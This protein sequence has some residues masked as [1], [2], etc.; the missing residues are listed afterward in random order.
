MGAV[1]QTV[2]ENIVSLLCTR[3]HHMHEGRLL[4]DV[5]E[6][7]HFSIPRRRLKLRWAEH[8]N[9]SASLWQRRLSSHGGP[10]ALYLNDVAC[11]IASHACIAFSYQTTIVPI[12]NADKQA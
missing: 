4:H 5:C 3:Y 6:L 1:L 9:I 2:L 11:S 10:Y 12:P 8:D 7:E